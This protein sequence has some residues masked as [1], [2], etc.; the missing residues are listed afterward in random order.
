MSVPTSAKHRRG[1]PFRFPLA[2]DAVSIDANVAVAVK[3]DSRTAVSKTLEDTLTHGRCN[4]I[5]SKLS[6]LISII[7]NWVDFG[8]FERGK[9]LKL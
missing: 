5:S 1:R 9:R 2:A 4:D 6:G 3:P 8:D 7:Q